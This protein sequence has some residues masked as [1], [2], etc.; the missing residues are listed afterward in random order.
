MDK[1]RK[2]RLSSRE[3]LRGRTVI[4]EVL[5]ESPVRS[6]AIAAY[7]TEGDGR[8][9]GFFVPKRIGNAVERNRHKRHMRE[10]YR[11]MKMKFPLG[12]IIFQMRES[13]GWDELCKDFE[14][15]AERF[16]RRSG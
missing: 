14:D 1:G 15:C 6:G 12:N 7:L 4:R 2:Q 11:K 3:N 8:R 13:A 9:V 10:I 5:Q 16:A